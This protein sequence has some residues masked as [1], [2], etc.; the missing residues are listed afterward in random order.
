MTIK[1]TIRK[2]FND[3]Y[4]H[5]EFSNIIPLTPG[6]YLWKKDES[7]PARAVQIW[8]NRRDEEGNGIPVAL[9]NGYLIGKHPKDFGG[10]WS[11]RLDLA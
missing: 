11:K 2:R 3:D 1:E 4:S 9:E 5:V 7:W 10:L 8:Y 6:V